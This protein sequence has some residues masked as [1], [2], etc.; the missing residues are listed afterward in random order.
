MLR[1]RH[2]KHL[3]LQKSV[4]CVRPIGK[5]WLGFA[6]LYQVY[7]FY[8]LFLHFPSLP[9]LEYSKHQLYCCAPTSKCPFL[10]FFS[11]TLGNSSLAPPLPRVR[12]LADGGVWQECTVDGASSW[13]PHRARHAVTQFPVVSY[14]HGA[15]CTLPENTY[16]ALKDRAKPV[17]GHILTMHHCR[18]NEYSNSKHIQKFAREVHSERMYI[19]EGCRFREDAH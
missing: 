3:L 14:Q 15:T 4:Q 16:I 10:A 2:F 8:S 9:W 6:F 1:R 13:S 17:P 19:Q 5:R 12:A 7:S 11:L 18:Q